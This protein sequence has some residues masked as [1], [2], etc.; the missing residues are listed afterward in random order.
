MSVAEVL[1]ELREIIQLFV[2]KDPRS[3]HSEKYKIDYFYK[4]MR[5]VRKAWTL[6]K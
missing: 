5:A 6:K 3:Q 4:N 2:Q 1:D